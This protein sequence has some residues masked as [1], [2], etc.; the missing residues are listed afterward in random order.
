MSFQ[1]LMIA[2]LPYLSIFSLDAGVIVILVSKMFLVRIYLIV[3]SIL[4]SDHDIHRGTTV[5][6]VLFFM[7]ILFFIVIVF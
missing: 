5:C 1:F 7:F 3:M 2:L 6:N 4:Y